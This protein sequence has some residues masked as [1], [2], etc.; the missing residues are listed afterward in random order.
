MLTNIFPGQVDNVI[1]GICLFVCPFDFV[2]QKQV[3]Q[4][5]RVEY[6]EL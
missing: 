1:F 3:K 5:L 2:H 4:D 6:T